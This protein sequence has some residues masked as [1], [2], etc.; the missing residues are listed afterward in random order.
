MDAISSAFLFEIRAGLAPMLHFG[1]TSAGQRLI[2]YVTGG[3]VEG[4]RLSGRLLPGGGDWAVV[5]SDGILA[6]DVRIVLETSDGNRILMTYGGRVRGATETLKRLL[7]PATAGSVPVTDYYFRTNPLFD[8]PVASQ[9]AWLNGIVAI[10]EGRFTGEGV[11]YRI[12]G[13]N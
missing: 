6:L 8:A 13:I 3:V 9:Y 11:S 4:P 12:F 5:R 2:A 1:E 7:D 10:G